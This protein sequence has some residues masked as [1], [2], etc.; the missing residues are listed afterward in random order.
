MHAS[1]G[2]REGHTQ[3]GPGAQWPCVPDAICVSGEGF[4]FR[5]RVLGFGFGFRVSGFWFRVSGFVIRLSGFASRV[6]GSTRSRCLT[7]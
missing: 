4:E 1:V 6:S 5:V 3:P 2:F 7:R